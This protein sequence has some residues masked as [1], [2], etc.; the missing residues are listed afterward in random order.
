DHF[1]TMYLFQP[2]NSP[3]QIAFFAR[4]A[5]I[6][7]NTLWLYLLFFLLTKI[8]SARAAVLGLFFFA[9]SQFSI[10]H[11][12]F[13]VI[14]FMSAILIGLALVSF[15]IYLKRSAEGRKTAWW[16]FLVSFFFFL[17]L[18]SKF[19]SIVLLPA[20]FS[21]GL[22][23]MIF[24]E[25]RDWVARDR[26]SIMLKYIFSYAAIVV[27][28]LF[29]VSV[30]YSFHTWN[31]EN[32]MLVQKINENYPEE[33][34]PQIGHSILA[35]MVYLNPLTKGL[36]EYANGTFMVVSRMVVSA[37]NTY[38]LGH[39]YGNEGAGLWYFPVLYATKLSLGL[40]FFT[41]LVLS[42]MLYGLFMNG[43]KR[44]KKFS[45]FLSNPLSLL[46]L[47]FIF[48][49][50][51]VTLRSTFQIGL[52][53]IMPVILAMALLTGKGVDAFWE[54]RLRKIRLKQIFA[55][56]AIL[57]LISVFLS[58][59]YY[60]EY[61]NILGG[62][63]DSGYKIATDSN[64]DWGGSDVRRLGR[65][66]TDNDVHEIYTQIFADVPLRYYFGDGQKFYNLQDSGI[67]PPS[68]SYLAVSVFEYMN[69]VYSKDIPPDRKYTILKSNLVARVGKTIFVYRIP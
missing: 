14:D 44:K 24:V 33:Q 9:I 25:V 21:G 22:L 61:Y 69:N 51:A 23:Y 30:F 11:G 46:L 3:D 58:F 49:Y 35:T 47:V 16:F 65:W 42:L 6:L 67:L 26:I 20:A 4:L 37:Q 34:L 29:F 50:M 45:D 56:A 2:G 60:L 7:A 55:I 12:S 66:M 17:A 68:G 39:V 28:A 31:M 13:V 53:H 10:A 48:S 36:A 41:L 15:G 62:G 1:G 64:Y 27:L 63:T 59:P 54:K 57:M 40:H 8:W 52:R 38:F 18:V 5:V 19:S 43:K 32:D